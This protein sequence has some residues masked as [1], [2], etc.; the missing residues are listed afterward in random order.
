MKRKRLFILALA[1]SAVAVCV[2]LF[3]LSGGSLSDATKTLPDGSVLT[4]RGITKGTK[5]RC[6]SGN[7][8]QRTVGRFVPD[9]WAK[10]LGAVVVTHNTANSTHILWVEQRRGHSKF[11]LG[12][13]LANNFSL[14]I[15]TEAGFD[16]QY[17]SALALATPASEVCGFLFNAVPTDTPRISVTA[18]PNPFD[19]SSSVTLEVRNPHFVAHRRWPARSCPISVEQDNVSLELERFARGPK[20][21]PSAWGL[22]FMELSFVIR[23][24]AVPTNNW[25]ARSVR[26]FNEPG[27]E[28]LPPFQPVEAYQ[29]RTSAKFPGGLSSTEPYKLRFELRRTTY[30]PDE[31]HTFV[32]V[33]VPAANGPPSRPEPAKLQGFMLV[34]ILTANGQI[35]ARIEPPTSDWRLDP[36]SIVD[37]GGR[38]LQP[39]GG[40]TSDGGFSGSIPLESTNTTIDVTFGLTR[41]RTLE[42]IARPS[43]GP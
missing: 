8:L 5:H 14:R 19:P 39:R 4:V 1:L 42:V 23:D 11:R 31:H 10:K 43:V 35:T 28:F 6:V 2:A 26:V 3:L 13:A 36:V 27:T 24:R 38:W 40:S 17:Q 32:A 37:V 20:N 34:L 22:P 33:P 30:G 21:P 15:V 9:P 25:F 29:G 7:L 16:R 41:L 18:G 12:T